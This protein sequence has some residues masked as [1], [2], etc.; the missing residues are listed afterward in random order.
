MIYE[1]KKFSSME[2]TSGLFAYF[3]FQIFL[4]IENKVEEPIKL[5]QLCKTTIY[6]LKMPLICQKKVKLELVSLARVYKV[7][8]SKR[9]TYISSKLDGKISECGI[10]K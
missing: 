3:V 4:S 6:L 8:T 10:Y 7:F 1:M 5:R 9:K 2:W